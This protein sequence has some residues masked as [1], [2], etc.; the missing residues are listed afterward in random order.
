MDIRL[1][2]SLTR[3]KETFAPLDSSDVRMYVCGPTVY[4]RAHIGNARPVVVFDMLYRLL[5]DTYG[6]QNVWYARNITDIDDKIMAKA[7]QTARSVQDVAAEAASWFRND[8]RE[9][10]ALP[11]THEPHATDFIPEMQSMI[12]TLL[13][14][15]RAY[16]ADRHVLFDT[17]AWSDYGALSGRT[18]SQMEASARAETAPFKRSITDFVL[19]KPS[20]LDQPGW[21]SPWGWG[22]PGWH[23]ECSAMS[24]ALFGQDF[25][26]HAG[27]A[28]LMFPHHENEIAQS[29]AAN[30]GS[31]FARYWLHNEMVQIDGKKMSKSLGNFTTVSD[32]LQR[33]W[34]GA[35][36]R[37]AILLTH[38]RKTVDISEERLSLARTKLRKWRDRAAGAQPERAE[39]VLAALSDDLNTPL[40]FTEMD[41]LS[42]VAPRQLRGALD[43]LGVA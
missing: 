18:L 16:E 14:A 26:I 12:R 41:R 6:V 8:M 5:A 1:Y 15:G 40:A 22:R 2:N 31:V 25:D 20:H 35:E 36:I 11:P 39:S 29:R 30:P 43:F 3:A 10:G 38:Y 27:G 9:L 13:A 32:L 17:E 4:D 42:K 34:S 28:D 37:L 23:I 7:A 33:G 24:T 19:W 21:S